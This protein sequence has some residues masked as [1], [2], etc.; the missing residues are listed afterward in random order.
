[1]K[2]ILIM[3]SLIIFVFSIISC[4]GNSITTN[5]TDTSTTKNVSNVI[6]DEPNTVTTNSISTLITDEPNFVT[7]DVSTSITTSVTT[8]PLGNDIDSFKI[9]VEVF[10]DKINQIIILN[11]GV[12][13]MTQITT[14]LDPN[15][16]IYIY[17]DFKP[18]YENQTGL[19]VDINRTEVLIVYKLLLDEIIEAIDSNEITD[20]NAFV[21]VN[22]NYFGNLDVSCS[23]SENTLIIKTDYSQD[24]YEV[25][26]ALKLG[27]DDGNLFIKN[28][29][30][31][32]SGTDE[33]YYYEEFVENVS[34][35]HLRFG[36]STTFSYQN[37]N[38]IELSSVQIVS[39]EGAAEGTG[40]QP[41][42]NVSWTEADNDIRYNYS[43]SNDM[44]ILSEYI[45][46]YNQY[47]IVLSYIDYDTFNDELRVMWNLLEAT[48]WDYA[49]IE[50][51]DYEYDAK[52]YKNDVSLIEGETIRAYI[53]PHHVLFSLDS[54]ISYQG[55]SD[56]LLRLTEYGL[57]FARG[58]YSV[59]FLNNAKTEGRDKAIN[60]KMFDISV[61][62]ADFTDSFIPLID[63]DLSFVDR[64]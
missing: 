37:I 59:A 26:S 14:V 5:N 13:E 1:M 16:D 42:Y 2:K 24:G 22:L 45:D 12:I 30:Y 7:T 3:C 19:E 35:M 41:A 15:D 44:S 28:M 43:L 6:T 36:G 8:S 55:L 49:I 17:D 54:N 29:D 61:F 63:P 9:N 39:A 53:N 32:K 23:F 50:D 51:I 11:G 60:F 52:I 10:R 57:D 34:Y 27:Y 47:G 58:L 21:S 62:D 18:V 64:H 20:L 38:A 40:L 56:E 25:F 46:F 33:Y 4:T 48:G 31:Y